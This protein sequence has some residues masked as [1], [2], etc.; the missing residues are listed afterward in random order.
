MKIF[1]NLVNLLLVIV[2]FSN[3]SKD[4]EIQEKDSITFEF[5]KENLQYHKQ[6]WK[7]KNIQNYNYT[8]HQLTSHSGPIDQI[9]QVRNGV[10]INSTNPDQ[11]AETIDDLY[12]KFESIANRFLDP[13]YKPNGR[14]HYKLEVY[15]DGNLNIPIR[16]VFITYSSPNGSG[17]SYRDYIDFEIFDTE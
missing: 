7:D 4:D 8:N 3:C 13:D 2:L 16:Y 11:K 15:C 1:L 12:E 6:K 17:I 14:E 9:I 10:A 5:N